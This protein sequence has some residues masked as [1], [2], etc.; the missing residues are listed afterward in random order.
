MKSAPAFVEADVS[1]GTVRFLRVLLPSAFS[2]LHT[3]VNTDLTV[4]LQLLH[5]AIN[6]HCLLPRCWVDVAGL[7]ITFQVIIVNAGME[8]IASFLWY[9]IVL[10]SANID[11]TISGASD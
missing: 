11:Q 9:S 3:D 2:P 1:L 5:A 7:H 4:C 6:G 10:Y 8:P